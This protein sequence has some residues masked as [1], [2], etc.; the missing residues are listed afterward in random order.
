M[1]NTFTNVNTQLIGNLIL[2]AY[3]KYMSPLRAFT[4]D[5]SPAASYRGATIPVLSVAGSTAASD[6]TNTYAIQGSTASTT[7][8][9]LDRHKYVS[10]EILDSE[11][12]DS[13]LLTVEAFAI[14]K[15]SQLADAVLS[16]VLNC[17]TSSAYT[18]VSSSIPIAAFS[19]SAVS[20]FSLQCDN[21][22]MPQYGRSML[23]NP[24]WHTRLRQDTALQN[25]SAFGNA[26]TIQKGIV[27]SID[28]FENVFK[29]HCLPSGTNGLLVHPSALVF[30]SRTVFPQEGHQYSRVQIFTDEQTGL[31]ITHLQWHDPL[32]GSLRSIFTTEY[33]FASGNVSGSIRLY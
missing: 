2:D 20:A 9:T 21:L 17:F 5:A 6:Y 13:S 15:G 26:E 27:P 29:T 24:T 22:Q 3:V 14:S 30:A 16:D 4:L 7:T 23:L 11:Y 19:A 33:G 18:P 31:S 28:T 12:R 10:W 8:V 25:A 1:S 32:V